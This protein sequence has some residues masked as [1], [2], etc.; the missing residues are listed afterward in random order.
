MID[1]DVAV[2]DDS[3]RAH[4]GESDSGVPEGCPDRQVRGDRAGGRCLR[5][6]FP[7]S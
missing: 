7:V 1:P 4:P 3:V 6:G 5:G 2:D